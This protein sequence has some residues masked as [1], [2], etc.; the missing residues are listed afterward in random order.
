M[1]KNKEFVYKTKEGGHGEG[2]NTGII[3]INIIRRIYI[4]NPLRP[5]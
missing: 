5:G 1:H 3:K 2:R 4:I